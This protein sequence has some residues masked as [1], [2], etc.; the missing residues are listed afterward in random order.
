MEAV[1]RFPL[2]SIAPPPVDLKQSRLPENLHHAVSEVLADIQVARGETYNPDDDGHII[3]TTPTD[4]DLLLAE[5]MG[6]RYRCSISRGQLQQRHRDVACRLPAISPR[7]GST[8][9]SL[10][11]SLPMSQI[12][13]NILLAIRFYSPRY[14]HRGYAYMKNSF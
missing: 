7:L 2:I 3:V 11:H 13:G 12:Y 4:N 1:R 9:P 6:S 10:T 8:F 5:R 14:Y